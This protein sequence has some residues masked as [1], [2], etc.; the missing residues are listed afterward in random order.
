MHGRLV[1]FDETLCSDARSLRGRTANQEGDASL[2]A[3]SIVLEGGVVIE[4]SWCAAG[5][6]SR[7]QGA[8]RIIVRSIP[9]LKALKDEGPREISHRLKKLVNMNGLKFMCT[10][11]KKYKLEW[12][13]GERGPSH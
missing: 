4:R 10:P 3:R 8:W 12:R 11:L 6:S 9:L 5:R 13:G 2:A 1:F 7:L